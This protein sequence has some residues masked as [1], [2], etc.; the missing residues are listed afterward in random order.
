[1]MLSNLRLAHRFILFAG[2]A[3]TGLA[4]LGGVSL[5]VF[6]MAKVNGPI[7]HDIKASSDLVADILPPPKF[8][9]EAH[10]TAYQMAS[11]S[12]P[13]VRDQL[14]SRFAQLAKEYQER[15]QVW[16]QALP[17]GEIRSGMVEDSF[18]PVMSYFELVN[19]ELIPAM[20]ADDR[21]AA[22][23]L[24]RVKLE[25][26]FQQHRKAIDGVVAAAY[27]E[28]K[29]HESLAKTWERWGLIAIVLCFVVTVV[30]GVILARVLTR[31]I[32]TPVTEVKGVLGAL[33]E[34]DLRKRAVANGSDEIADMAAFL[35][36]TLDGLRVTVEGITT[37][38]HGVASAAE[39][40]SAVSKQLTSSVETVS[41]QSGSS[42]SAATEIG[43]SIHTVAAGMEELGASINE[44]AKSAE[45]AV[46]VAKEGVAAAE[47]ANAAMGRLKNSSSEIGEI[48]KLITGIAEQTNLL[49]LNATIEAARAGDA[50]RGFAVVAA[51]VKDLARKTGEATSD[52]SAK[53]GGIQADSHATQTALLRIS[54]II[55]KI[56]DF[57]QAIA[58][59]VEEQSATTKE[60]SSNINQVAQAGSSIASGATAV[61]GA[62]KEAAS[63]ASDTR[64]AA[65]ELARLAESLR[66]A[67][68]RFQI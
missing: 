59:A 54:E 40:L 41:M 45:Q 29:A 16:V 31:G 11:T 13:A 5:Y 58:G 53:V 21:G 23:R 7:Y 18:H 63:G 32:V 9:V 27:V 10:L 22:E 67:V 19:K 60:F 44:I 34:G 28:I 64:N 3:I 17:P 4:V 25:G 61:A 62:A 30:A 65:Q 55:G 50:G 14:I 39:E 51:E 42:A 56:S 57:Q 49:A 15:H 37:G 12:D 20:K 38:A 46:G 48:V 68:A 24:V 33:A 6:S 26:L 2:I 1:M 36:G 8:I 43:Q 35:N 66:Q 52:I 47:E